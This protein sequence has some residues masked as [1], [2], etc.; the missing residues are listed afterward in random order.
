M[1]DECGDG[2]IVLFRSKDVFSNAART[3]LGSEYD[4][5]AVCYRDERQLWVYE[6]V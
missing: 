1:E 4:H 6:A 2:D 5:V 3:V